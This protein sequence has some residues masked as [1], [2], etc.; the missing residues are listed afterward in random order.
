M[1]RKEYCQV[2]FQSIHLIYQNVCVCKQSAP[3]EKNA[4]F[5][6]STASCIHRLIHRRLQDTF[7]FLIQITPLLWE[8]HQHHPAVSCTLLLLGFL[9][10]VSHLHRPQWKAGF[11]GPTWQHWRWL[12][13]KYPVAFSSHLFSST[14]LFLY[15][16]LF[17]ISRMYFIDSLFHSGCLALLYT[18]TPT[19]ACALCMHIILWGVLATDREG[20]D[21]PSIHNK[22]LFPTSSPENAFYL[23]HLE[24]LFCWESCARRLQITKDSSDLKLRAHLTVC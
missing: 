19:L 21:M 23:L 2:C 18:H 9:C 22:S 6:G 12:V 16:Y 3:A 15:F 4:V 10:I 8:R 7:N 5:P 13:H 24:S 1:K 11:I 14:S 20:I 17:Y